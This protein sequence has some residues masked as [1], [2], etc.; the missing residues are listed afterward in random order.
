MIW[1]IL[2]FAKT[3][4]CGQV[5][6]LPPAGFWGYL[7]MSVQS[8]GGS[9]VYGSAYPS[10]A[11]SQD[12]TAGAPFAPSSSDAAGSSAASAGASGASASSPSGA[13]KFPALFGFDVTGGVTA[14]LPDGITLGVWSLA[15]E[16]SGQDQPSSSSGSPTGSSSGS[17]A[18]SGGG[19][20]YAAMSAALDQMV[21]QFLAAQLAGQ[22]TSSTSSTTPT[23]QQSSAYQQGSSDSSTPSGATGTVA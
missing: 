3:E 21:N 14:T 19:P 13:N 15:P 7:R 5:L 16:G 2:R 6:A 10:S 20:D 9:A 18:S 22:T 8:I 17:S 23:A 1:Y 11:K 4:T 12:Q